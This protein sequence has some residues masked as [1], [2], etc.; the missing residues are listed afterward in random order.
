MHK[1]GEESMHI[2]LG[3]S[4][5]TS[6]TNAIQHRS[7]NINSLCIESSVE[8]VVWNFVLSMATCQALLILMWPDSEL[9]PVKCRERS[10]QARL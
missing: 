7:V 5:L 2:R 6:K 9:V 4:T 8:T 1:I 3:S 10:S